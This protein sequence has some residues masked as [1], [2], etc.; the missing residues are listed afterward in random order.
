MFSREKR[1][2]AS[3]WGTLE[4]SGSGASDFG[5]SEWGRKSDGNH[6]PGRG[7]DFLLQSHRIKSAA[8]NCR[9]CFRYCRRFGVQTDIR[10][11]TMGVLLYTTTPFIIGDMVKIP[12][13]GKELNY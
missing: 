1:F 8:S 12:R 3:T 4:K 11:C 6:H 9:G 10:E 2:F 5:E 13:E 7:G